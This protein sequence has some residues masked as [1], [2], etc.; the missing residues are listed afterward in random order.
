MPFGILQY[1]QCILHRLTCV[2]SIFANSEKC[3]F[4][5]AQCDGFPAPL[6]HGYDPLSERFFLDIFELLC[7]VKYSSLQV[8]VGGFELVQSLVF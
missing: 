5:V 6:F 7:S 2:P 1:V 8:L 4:A 3:Q